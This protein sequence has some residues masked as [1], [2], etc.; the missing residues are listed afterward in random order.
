MPLQ[1][2]NGTPLHPKPPVAQ[3]RGVAFDDKVDDSDSLT[4][5]IL[6]IEHIFQ[7]GKFWCWAA[8]IDMVLRYYKKKR[9]DKQC[10]IVKRK[11][12]DPTHQCAADYNSRTDDCDPVLMAKAWRACGITEV[13]PV[14]DP[15]SLDDI[16]A[17]LKAH[18]PLQVGIGWTRGGGHAVLIKGWAATSPESLVIDDPLRESPLNLPGGSGRATYD[19]LLGALGHGVWQYTWTSLE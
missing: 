10:A 19:E 9:P 18:R 6:N 1:L 2:K 14:N 15:M 7:E 13:V 16:K 3:T 4:P 12:G 8:C 17:E 5:I 11:L